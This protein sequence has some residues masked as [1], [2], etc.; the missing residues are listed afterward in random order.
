MKKFPNHKNFI[1]SELIA[2]EIY[3]LENFKNMLEI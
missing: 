3:L 1:N 2:L